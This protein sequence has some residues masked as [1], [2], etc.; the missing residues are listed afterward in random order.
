LND[1]IFSIRC[2]NFLLHIFFA[3]EIQNL[4]IHIF[5]HM[6]ENLATADTLDLK[7]KSKKG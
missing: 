2:F 5:Q 3:S 6:N 4:L 1:D 7:N